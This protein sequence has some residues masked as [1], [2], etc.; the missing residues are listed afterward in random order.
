MR[1]LVAPSHPLP[2][3][4]TTRSIPRSRH[5]ATRALTS[6]IA[7]DLPR[8]I[9]AGG[10]LAN[11]TLGALVCAMIL[12]RDGQIVAEAIL[13]PLIA[14]G[15]VAPLT[16]LLW[17]VASVLNRAAWRSVREPRR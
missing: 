8:A 15:I 14:I 12:S 11:G 2:A 7:N 13:P 6:R 3:P 10:W 17:A 1:K 16:V 4:V 5:L 9:A